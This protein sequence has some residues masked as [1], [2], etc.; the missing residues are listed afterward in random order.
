MI[1]RAAT[2]G[3]VVLLLFAGCS[4]DYEAA[5]LAEA[6]PDT[7]PNAEL[8]GFSHTVVRRGRLV[9]S[10]EAETVRRF[11]RH[12][13]QQLENVRFQEFNADGDLVASG[14][15]RFARFFGESENVELIGDIEFS[16]E[17]EDARIEAEYLFWDRERRM[18]YGD[19]D[20][21]VSVTR[22][23][24]TRLSGRG[25]EVDLRRRIIDF[26]GPVEGVFIEGADE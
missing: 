1:G 11:D 14:S 20:E 26:A 15:G 13:E 12:D 17:V 23:D 25:F 22:A 10:I 8:T 18:L 9:F 7:T 6:I 4:L 21:T 2:R 3:F 5:R 24:G 16:T 19:P